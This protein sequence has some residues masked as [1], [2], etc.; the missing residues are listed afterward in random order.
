M[1]PAA[2]MNLFKEL[3]ASESW[4][5]LRAL[6]L[7]ENGGMIFGVCE[8]LGEATPFAAW[9]WRVAFLCAIFL[10]G[11][12]LLAYLIL[13]IAIPEAEPGSAQKS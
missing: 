6:R 7:P 12:G 11:A 5:K 2:M 13:H 3:F 1:H 10:W 8:A 9:M 4:K